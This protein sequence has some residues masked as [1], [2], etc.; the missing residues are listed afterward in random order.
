M[1]IKNEFKYMMGQ[2]EDI[3]VGECFV[4]LA[5]DEDEVFLYLKIAGW[6]DKETG[7]GENAVLLSTGELEYFEGNENVLPVDA[8][9][10]VKPK[11]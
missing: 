10:T 5:P 8:T 4:Y 1:K 11:E 2:F 7:D 3:P 6:Y 9:I